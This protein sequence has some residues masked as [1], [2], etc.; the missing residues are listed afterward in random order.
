VIKRLAIATALGLGLLAAVPAGAIVNGTAAPAGSF[1][2]TA[3][4]QRG[5]GSAFCGGSVIA[6]QWVLTAAHCVANG[7]ANNLFVVT[8]RTDLSDKT[9]GQRIEVDVVRVN[10]AYDDNLMSHDTALLHLATRTTSPSI[11]LATSA[12][13]A[14]ERPGTRVTVTGWGDQTP[15]L[16]LNS[17][18]RLRSVDL[19]VVSDADCAD[20]NGGF[21][22]A[23]GVCAE[24]LLKDSCQGDS[25]GPLFG[26]LAGRAIQIG[27]VSYGL[28]CATPTF[29]GVY[30]E[31]N[32]R[33]IRTWIQQVAR[34]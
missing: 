25:G 12:H 20:A 27:V 2:F 17:S 22:A 8:G 7:S 24:A 15:T 3:S 31:V 29:P 19:D 13:E 10:P 5:N 11:R 32:N 4:L 6:P 30:S 23:S 26:T 21:H 33:Q 28:G 14:L 34:V 18:K 1:A 16:G 9:R